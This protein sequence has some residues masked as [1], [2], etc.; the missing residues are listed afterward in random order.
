M[1]NDILSILE[2][3]WLVIAFVC[4]AWIVWRAFKPGR[5]AEMESYG[6][7]PLNERD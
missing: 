4:F 6:S 7:I 3:F 2:T 1:G 5:K